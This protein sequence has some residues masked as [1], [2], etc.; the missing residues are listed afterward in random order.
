[1]RRGVGLGALVFA[2]IAALAGCSGADDE[3]TP[4]TVDTIPADDEA[5]SPEDGLTFTRSGG[6]TYEMHEAAATCGPSS[7][8]EEI[9]V[10]KLRSPVKMRHKGNKPLEPF[11]YVDVLPGVAG[12]YELPLDGGDDDHIGDVTIFSFD[13]ENRNELSGS[14]E[15]ATGT[16]TVL[17]ATC[18]PEPRI[19][20][21]IRATLASEYSDLPTMHVVGGLGAVGPS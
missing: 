7:E 8:H 19:S 2:C 5:P 10:V 9:A 3:P 12:T 18:E 20:F 15:E 14:R 17:E 16:L 1:M 11:L 6:T 21:T 4:L 13:N